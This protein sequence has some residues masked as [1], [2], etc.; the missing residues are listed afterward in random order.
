MQHK[1]TIPG[2]VYLLMSHAPDGNPIAIKVGWS[3]NVQ[4][5]IKQ[6]ERWKGEIKLLMAVPGT[7]AQEMRIHRDLGRTYP[8]LS[9]EWYGLEARQ[10]AM[11]LVMLAAG[12]KD[13]SQTDDNLNMTN[14]M[15]GKYKPHNG[16]P[17]ICKGCKGVL[18]NDIDKETR[19]WATTQRPKRPPMPTESRKGKE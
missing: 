14:G 13:K 5:R 17:S 8:R 6:I 7:M 18:T 3:K 9:K 15:A 1:Y 12:N 19:D 2:T 4:K 10:L 11:S 16:C